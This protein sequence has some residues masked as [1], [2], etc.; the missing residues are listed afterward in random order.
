MQVKNLKDAG[1]QF[2]GVGDLSRTIVGFVLEQHPA[3]AETVTDEV[4][5]ALYEGFAV[6]FH[7]NRGE[8]VYLK[9][10]MG[11]LIFAGNTAKAKGGKAKVTKIPAGAVCYGVHHVHAYSPQQLGMLKSKDHELHSILSAINNDFR[12]YASNTLKDMQRKA[13]EM[14]KEA[15]GEKQTR[16][17][18]FFLDSV[19]SHFDTLDKQ[20]K[21][22]AKRKDETADELRWKSAKEA[23]FKTYTK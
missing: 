11:G 19:K 13:R 20:V 8:D 22:A 3:F 6:R 17:M 7:E 18:V 2:A 12:K 21:N 5:A 14:L 16:S 1:Y 23:F 9:G 10:D 4:R 15:S